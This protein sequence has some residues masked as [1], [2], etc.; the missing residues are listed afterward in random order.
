MWSTGPRLK[1]LAH[2]AAGRCGQMAQRYVL[3]D[4]KLP[5][6]P[7]DFGEDVF[8][9][10]FAL[11]HVRL[12]AVSSGKLPA[13]LFYNCRG[14]ESVEL[15]DG[16]R[17]IGDSALSCCSELK[18][19]AIPESVTSIGASAFG[20]CSKLERVNLPAGLKSIGAR[21]FAN[22][23]ALKEI[24]IPESVKR[25]PD[26][27]FLGSPC[28]ESVLKLKASRRAAQSEEN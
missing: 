26:N 21:A 4:L 12:P 2:R 10:C 25:I 17:I 14:L 1:A 19:V 9:S 7:V 16:I 8:E 15:P 11:R 27:A 23:R 18:E 28:E 22:C 13:K 3:E 20:G 5:A 6:G 24:E